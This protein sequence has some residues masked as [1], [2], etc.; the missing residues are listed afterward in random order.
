MSNLPNWEGASAVYSKA[1]RILREYMPGISEPAKDLIEALNSG[2]EERI[3][4]LLL[5]THIYK[6][7]L[8]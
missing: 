6:W 3:K 1:Y 8:E 7:P 2:D 5:M 4:G